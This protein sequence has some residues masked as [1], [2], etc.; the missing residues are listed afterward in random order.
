M[1]LQVAGVIINRMPAEP[2]PVTAEAPHQLAALAS[3]ELL[4]VLP[5]VAGSDEERIEILANEIAS[6]PTLP[7]LMHAL[8]IRRGGPPPPPP[9]PPAPK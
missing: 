9:Q 3:A 7:W 8:G 1:G 4:G 2:D 5:E 6:Q